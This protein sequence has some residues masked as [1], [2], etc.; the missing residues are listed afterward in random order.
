MY[1]REAR[2]VYNEGVDGFGDDFYA[3]FNQKVLKDKW[4]EYKDL[5][6]PENPDNYVMGSSV[7]WQS[8][9]AKTPTS[10]PEVPWAMDVAGE[11]SSINGEWFWEFSSDDLHQIDDAEEIRDHLFKAIYG[12]FYN[13]KKEEKYSCHAMEWMSYLLGKRESRRLIGDYIYSFEDVKKSTKPE[14]AVAKG[15]RHVDV[16]YQQNIIDPAV[17]D[18]ISDALYYHSPEYYIPYRSLYSKNISNLFM[19]GRNFSCTHIGL[20][21]PRVMNTTAQMG[22]AVGYAASVC[23]KHKLLPRDVY[24]KHLHELIMLIEESDDEN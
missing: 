19:A 7:L 2:S 6:A 11:H 20:G 5:W 10:F 9:E 21:G 23:H 22:C 3:H 4:S 18:F 1:G 14:D 13:A 15:K 16:H 24:K 12:A 17:P 8:Y